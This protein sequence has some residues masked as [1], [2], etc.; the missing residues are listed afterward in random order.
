MGFNQLT[1]TSFDSSIR[2]LSYGA[3]ISPTKGAVP[4]AVPPDQTNLVLNTTRKFCTPQLEG[5]PS[6]NVAIPNQKA[7]PIWIEFP[8]KGVHDEIIQMYMAWD[9]RE[10]CEHAAAPVIEAPSPVIPDELRLQAL[11][12]GTNGCGADGG[13]TYINCRM[14]GW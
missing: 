6:G 2:T 13:V 3:W 12:N 9:G 14:Y 10:E 1:A 7:D 11:K 4:E 5:K 8:F